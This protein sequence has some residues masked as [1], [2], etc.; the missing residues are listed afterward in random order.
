M[1]SLPSNYRS[2]V[3][4]V[5]PRVA[6]SRVIRFTRRR[7][8]TTSTKPRHRSS[9]G[10]SSI[11]TPYHW[12]AA[13]ALP[14]RP[15]QPRSLLGKSRFPPGLP[16]INFSSTVQASCET[17][18]IDPPR[19]PLVSAIQPNAFCRSINT[20][21]ASPTDSI[22]PRSHRD[23][24]ADSISRFPLGQ[25]RLIISAIMTRSLLALGTALLGASTVLAQQ[26]CSL[27]QKCPKE[28]PCCSRKS[29][30]PIP[31]LRPPAVRRVAAGAWCCCPRSHGVCPMVQRRRAR[32]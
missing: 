14:R 26:T 1:A 23:A 19:L 22:S 18:Q 31:N 8:T 20:S 4:L 9:R 3:A 12:D 28:A 21:K 7:K 10:V 27:S 17:P 16:R 25:A 24:L 2:K 11:F 5:A 6:R 13:S 30:V 15:P 32:D 29:P